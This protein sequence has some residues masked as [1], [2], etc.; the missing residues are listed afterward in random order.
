MRLGEEVLAMSIRGFRVECGR[1][2]RRSN[3]TLEQ[4]VLT[5]MLV[6]GIDEALVKDRRAWKAAICQPGPTTDRMGA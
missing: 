6:C 1:E 4:V 2:K 5:G 3:L